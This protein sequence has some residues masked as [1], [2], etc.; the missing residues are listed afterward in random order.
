MHV[1]IN[2]WTYL[3]IYIFLFLIV[4]K[5]MMKGNIFLD[6]IGQSIVE[7][8]KLPASNAYNLLPRPVVLKY[9]TIQSLMLGLIWYVY[10]YMYMYIYTCIYISVYKNVHLCLC[11]YLYIYINKR[12]LSKYLIIESLMLGLIW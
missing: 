1:F 12:M 8:K 9:L 10:I 7:K 6:R 5:K 4:G 2:I 11:I 3:Y